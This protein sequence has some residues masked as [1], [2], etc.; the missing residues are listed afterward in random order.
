MSE[1]IKMKNC[2]N[3]AKHFD[4]EIFFCF[5]IKIKNCMQLCACVTAYACVHVRMH[6]CLCVACHVAC[7]WYYICIK[8]YLFI[9]ALNEIK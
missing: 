2:N 7:S 5:C 3:E 9:Q 1:K 8:L 4:I 6:V